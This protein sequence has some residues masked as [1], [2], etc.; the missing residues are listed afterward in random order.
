MAT[1]LVHDIDDALLERISAAAAAHQ[2]TVDGEVKAVLE[3]AFDQ[4]AFDRE[5]W[6]SEARQLRTQVRSDPEKL[7]LTQFIADMRDE[8]AERG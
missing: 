2:R 5:A 3:L 6:V 8:Q 4:R 1:L 7:P